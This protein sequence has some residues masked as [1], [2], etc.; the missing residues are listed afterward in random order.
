[1]QEIALS[2]L[3]ECAAITKTYV[4]STHQVFALK[5]ITLTI[6]RGE[7]VAMMGASGSGK[8]TLLNVLGLLDVP[9]EGHYH[10]DGQDTGLLSDDEKSHFR[11][12]RIGF[13]FQ[14]FFLLPKLTALEN[15]MLPLF[16]S[17]LDRALA[18]DHSLAMLNK[19]GVAELA[20]HYPNQ[21]SGG[22]QQRVAIARALVTN[23]DIILAD[24]PTGALD[25]KT[26]QAVMQVLLALH[27][28][29]K[30]V[31]IITHDPL[32]AK[33]CQR[34]IALKDGLIVN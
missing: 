16:Y 21:L 33:Q 7:C 5:G 24:E 27:Q 12:R 14:A 17:E 34:V 20:M 25:S 6:A 26:G 31:I 4:Q 32:I 9:S 3:I 30:T 28:E 1:M 8:S 10:F 2:C 19:M 18:K 15:V 11:N 13:V 29:G 23:P 22:Q